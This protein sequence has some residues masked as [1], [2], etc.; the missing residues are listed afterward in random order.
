VNIKDEISRRRFLGMVGGS[1]A[2]AIITGAD[3]ATPS[4]TTASRRP[5]G[6]KDL[7]VPVIATGLPDDNRGM[8]L[9]MRKSLELGMN[10]WVTA[11]DYGGGQSEEGIGRYF[12]RFP[13]D[14]EKVI[15]QTK[16]HG[17]D[18]QALTGLLEKSLDR[19]NTSWIDQFY[20]HGLET[21]NEFSP[22]VR[23][24]V[25]KE[26]RAG[27]IRQFG[28]STHK[29]MEDLMLWAAAQGWIDGILFA[30]NYRLM[31]TG[32]MREAVSACHEAGIGLVAMKTRAAVPGKDGQD[33]YRKLIERFRRKG[34]DINQVGVLA[35][36]E[37]RRIASACCSIGNFATLR[38]F[39]E[40]AAEPFPLSSG[41]RR[42]LDEHARATNRDYCSGCAGLCEPA[43]PDSL[44]ISDVMRFLMYRNGYGE[45]DR[46]WH[47]FNSIP[48]DV[49]KRLSMADFSD[50][51]ARCP[52][53]MPIAKLM[54]EAAE[55]L[56]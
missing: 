14:R 3:A 53:G 50:A 2:G 37:D 42:V 31:N 29:N 30:Y 25:S 34:Y 15:I 12:K 54:R 35:V 27:R 51:E 36:L 38:K 48:A 28:F 4:H 22:G 10:Y 46:A 40:L 7:T 33:G 16:V 20:L 43:V 5:F 6:R 8:L 44:P 32:K 55:V 39:A 45:H 24:W 1:C 11:A 47:C 13:S 56:A 49:R 19:M 23:E 52:N 21:R 17:R 18:S 9:L 41:D 26:K